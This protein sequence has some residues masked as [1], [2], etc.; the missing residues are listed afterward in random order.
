MRVTR[1]SSGA[2]ETRLW[3]C[4]AVDGCE[5]SVNAAAAGGDR[6]TLAQS[7]PGCASK[8]VLRS[9]GGAVYWGGVS[10]ETIAL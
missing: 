1:R 10:G 4:D 9:C 8:T 7:W 5:I 3:G 6:G 2:E